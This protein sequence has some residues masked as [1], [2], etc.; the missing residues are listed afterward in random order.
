MTYQNSLNM[1]RGGAKMVEKRGWG[2]AAES[3]SVYPG[4]CTTRSAENKIG[5]LL[6]VL[7][8]G[9]G[10]G[11]GGDVTLICGVNAFCQ[12]KKRPAWQV[13]MHISL[14]CPC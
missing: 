13:V 8:G 12:L 4:T 5:F 6:L 9:V 2:K 1:G 10:G 3:R 11:G 14:R 7:H